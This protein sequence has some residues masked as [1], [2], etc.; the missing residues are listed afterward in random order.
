M[1]SFP[2]RFQGQNIVSAIAGRDMQSFHEYLS[3]LPH[4][5]MCQ[6]MMGQTLL[7]FAVSQRNMQAVMH[8]LAAGADPNLITPNGQTALDIALDPRTQAEPGYSFVLARAGGKRKADM[9]IT[10]IHEKLENRYLFVIGVKPLDA[11]RLDMI[12]NAHPQKMQGFVQDFLHRH[13]GY[14]PLHM[15]V[16]AGDIDTARF[17]LEK[18]LP[19]D[20]K[21][22]DGRLVIEMEMHKKNASDAM[23]ELLLQHGERWRNNPPVDAFVD[24]TVIVL[25]PDAKLADLRKPVE[26]GHGVT[27][28]L[29]YRIARYGD[30]NDIVRIARAD[31]TDGLRAADLNTA[32][33]IWQSVLDLA[34]ERREAIP[35]LAPDLWVGRRRELEQVML[36][37]DRKLHP[38]IPC[39]DILMRA[40]HLTFK[41]NSATTRKYKM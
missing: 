37:I 4:P 41:K 1:T 11:G 14:D 18:G 7:H 3:R 33:H 22:R 5:D 36:R 32:T 21:A 13:E 16:L 10:E 2:P 26:G 25:P 6:D 30:I 40:T 15:A 34:L 28:T 27:D 35:L 20:R 9:S 29:L 19:P 23:V 17:W 24:E 12:V 8:L 39:E 38:E 31:Q